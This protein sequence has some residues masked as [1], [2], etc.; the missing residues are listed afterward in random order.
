MSRPWQIFEDVARSREL[1]FRY[2]PLLEMVNSR[3]SPV[4]VKTAVG[5]AGTCQQGA[6][7]APCPT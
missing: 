2:L 6:S 1:C 5:P 3:T 4:P 7:A